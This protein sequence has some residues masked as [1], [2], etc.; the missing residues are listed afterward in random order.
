M[1]EQLS[2]GWPEHLDELLERLR[3]DGF[4]VGVPE[5]LRLHQL[6]L[7]LASRGLPLDEPG[8]LASLLGPVLCRSA[9]EQEAFRR[10]VEQWWP[11]P[12]VVE[13]PGEGAQVVATAKPNQPPIPSPAPAAA[14][15][16]ALTRVERR[17]ARLLRWLPA[18]P[19]AL[20][21]AAGLVA[22]GVGG[23]MQLQRWRAAAPGQ[24]MVQPAPPNPIPQPDPAPKQDPAPSARPKKPPTPAPPPIELARD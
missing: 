19:V 17:R 22:A 10:H 9:S 24:G 20:A 16:E 6:L 15:E 21:L 3:Q 13:T 23:V 2:G 14:L 1:A 18:T 5:T 8:R 4:R 12:P 11:G 7:A